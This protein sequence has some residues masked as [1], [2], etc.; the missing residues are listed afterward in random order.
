MKKYLKTISEFITYIIFLAFIFLMKLIGIDASSK[1]CGFLL[2]KIGKLTRTGNIVRNNLKY[3][4]YSSEQIKFLEEKIWENFG[5]YIGEF[6]FISQKFLEKSQRIE[7]VGEKN[8]LDLRKDGKKFMIFSGHFANWDFV[9]FDILKITGE[10]GVVYRKINNRFID[11]YV[12]NKRSFLGVKMIRKGPS[13][14]KDLIKLVK[15]N[16]NIMMLI[17][18][19]MNEGIN[20][21]FMG[22]AS[23]TPEAPAL[24]ARQYNYAIVPMKIIRK[25]GANFIIEFLKPFYIEKTEDKNYDI[26]NTMEKVNMIISSWIRSKPEDW[27]WM[28]QRWGKPHEMNDNNFHP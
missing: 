7:I 4:G 18:Q 2:K 13:G 11:Q 3:T 19:K 22:K 23:N 12:R 16:Q 24:I 10:S 5:R 8:I 6:P 26:K 1:F 28:H 27:F 20:I 14:A 9:L 15:N 25:D 17:D 21:P